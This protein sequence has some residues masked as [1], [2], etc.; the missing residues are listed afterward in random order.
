MKLW[1]LFCFIF[2]LTAN[3]F[4]AD[5][6]KTLR[7]ST[8]PAGAEIYLGNRPESFIQNAEM[9]SPDSISLS[10]NDSTVRVTVFKPGYADTTLDIHLKSQ[11][12]NFVWIELQEESDLDKLEWQEAILNK[13]ENRRTGKLLFFAG[14]IPLALSGTFF[15]L[16]EWKFHQADDTRKKIDNSLI[17]EGKH[18][19]QLQKDFHDDKKSGRNFRTAA[20]VSLGISA[21]LLG[22]AAVFYF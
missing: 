9:H 13:R 14:T 5:S 15:G 2:C 17:R 20:F 22:A 10:P 7:I 1:I 8:W 18:F 6:T 12:K 19:Q 4:A 16:A 11:T 21:A 3:I